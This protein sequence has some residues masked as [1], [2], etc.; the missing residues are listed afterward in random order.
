MQISNVYRR[1]LLTLISCTIIMFDCL[2]GYILDHY[3]LYFLIIET[4]HLP[5]LLMRPPP[6]FS[7]EIKKSNKHIHDFH[8]RQKKKDSILA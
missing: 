5:L 7:I 1:D 3:L 4:H 2:F 8:Q 6:D